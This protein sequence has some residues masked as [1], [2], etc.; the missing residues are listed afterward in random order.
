MNAN[1]KQVD[2]NRFAYS[3][4]ANEG[5]LDASS[6]QDASISLPQIGLFFQSERR[7]RVLTLERARGNRPSYKSDALF[8]LSPTSN[9]VA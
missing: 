6:I 4:T 5:A 2:A 1:I 3:G 9:S 7:L 8:L